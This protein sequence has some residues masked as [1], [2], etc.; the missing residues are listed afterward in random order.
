MTEDFRRACIAVEGAGR[1]AMRT[2]NGDVVAGRY[3]D[4]ESE[5]DDPAG[6]G[7]ISFE[8]GDWSVRDVYASE[9]AELIEPK[10]PR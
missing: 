5:W 10:E 6:Y 4:Y 9:F 1:G 3:F 2:K 8:G 7:Y